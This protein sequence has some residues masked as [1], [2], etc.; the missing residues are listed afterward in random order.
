MEIELVFERY[1]IQT[2]AKKAYEKRIRKY[3]RQKGAASAFLEH[4]ID[5][6]KYFLETAD[7]NWLRTQCSQAAETG[8][9]L[10]CPENREDVH[11]K[12]TQTTLPITPA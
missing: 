1:C 10:V 2:A 4:E 9:I 8:A 3:F 11:L 5:V 12:F 7:F 6:L